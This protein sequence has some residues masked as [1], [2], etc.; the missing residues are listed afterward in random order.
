MEA[1]RGIQ[2][3]SEAVRG[4]QSR[5]S[6]AIRGHQWSSEAI[7]GHQR[8]SDAIRGRQRRSE[9]VRGRHRLM[10]L[11][12][13]GRLSMLGTDNITNWLSGRA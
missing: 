1:I 2:R 9:A 8:S 7:R 4:R 11:G 6:E 13:E 10:S 5:P 3:P 12:L